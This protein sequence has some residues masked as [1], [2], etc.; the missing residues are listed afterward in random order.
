MNESVNRPAWMEDELVKDIP[1]QKLDFLGTLFKEGHGRNQKEMISY[2]MPMMK[3][4]KQ[5]NLTF[6][7]QEMNAAIAAIKKYSSEEELKQIDKILKEKE[8]HR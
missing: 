7:P 3:K 2:L 1:Q 8:K 5:E 6:T 4:A